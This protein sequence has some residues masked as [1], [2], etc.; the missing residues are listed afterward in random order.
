VRSIIRKSDELGMIELR[1]VTLVL[2]GTVLFG[3]LIERA[4]LVVA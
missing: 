2:L 4:G 1:P 3:L